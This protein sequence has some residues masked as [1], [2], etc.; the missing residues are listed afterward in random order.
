MDG[1]DLVKEQ[2]TIYRPEYIFRKS[3]VDKILA[4]LHVSKCIPDVNLK[5][6]HVKE[7]VKI[8]NNK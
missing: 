1:I 2:C 4:Q 6:Y 7:L 8:G 5:L 3:H